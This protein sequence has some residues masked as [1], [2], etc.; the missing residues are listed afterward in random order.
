MKT[1]RRRKPDLLQ[2]WWLLALLLAAQAF[3]I[4]HRVQHAPGL[5]AALVAVAA[6]AKGTAT[7]TAAPAGVERHHHRHGL[8]HEADSA[9]CRLVDQLGHADARFAGSGDLAFA[10]ASAPVPLHTATAAA[11]FWPAAAYWARGPPLARLTALA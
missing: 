2:V 8:G 6:A 5:S 1:L 10:A 4:A 9:E 11:W 7:A 3:G